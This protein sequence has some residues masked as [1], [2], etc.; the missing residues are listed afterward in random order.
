MWFHNLTEIPHGASGLAFPILV[1]GLH[2]L[3]VQVLSSFI[4]E[5]AAATFLFLLCYLFSI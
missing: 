1:A 4:S 5:D 3:N 2:Y